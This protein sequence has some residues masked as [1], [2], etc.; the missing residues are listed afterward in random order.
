MEEETK[1]DSARIDMIVHGENFDKA[2]LK[3][4]TMLVANGEVTIG[5][6]EKNL[7]RLNDLV[8]RIKNS[9]ARKVKSFKYKTKDNLNATAIVLKNE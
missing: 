9:K 8:Q 7:S 5:A 4:N 6:T 1:D 2:F 3:A